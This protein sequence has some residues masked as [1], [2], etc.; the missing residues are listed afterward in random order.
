MRWDPGARRRYRRGCRMSE[1]VEWIIWL[2]FMEGRVGIRSLNQGAIKD[3]L[4]DNE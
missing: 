1:S 2:G 3:N 4:R